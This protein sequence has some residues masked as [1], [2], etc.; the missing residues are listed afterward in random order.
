M[1]YGP[2]EYCASSVL[3]PQIDDAGRTAT[4]GPEQM[5]DGRLDT[6]WVE[7]KSGNGEGEWVLVDFGSSRHISA[8]EIYNGYHKNAD[9]F[10]KNNRIRDLEIVFSDGRS[11]IATL[12]D[13]AGPQTINVGAD[14]NAEWVQ[15][16]IRSVYEGTRYRDT[17]ITELRIITPP[18]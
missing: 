11:Q 16:K 1:Q 8:L 2:I 4:Y 17:A 15:I 18:R 7:G 10:R 12:A 13:R 9:L 3:R 6:A 5:I 14:I